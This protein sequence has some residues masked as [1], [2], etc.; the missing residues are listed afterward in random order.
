MEEGKE[1]NSLSQTA[2]A[3]LDLPDGNLESKRAAQLSKKL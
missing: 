1:R 3:R 2:G